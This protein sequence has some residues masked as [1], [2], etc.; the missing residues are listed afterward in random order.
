MSTTQWSWRSRHIVAQAL[1]PSRSRGS[2]PSMAAA[3]RFT[4]TISPPSSTPTIPSPTASR[5]LRCR[6]ES[7]CSSL[8][9]SSTLRSRS[10]RV[11]WLSELSTSCRTAV[12][13]SVTPAI[14]QSCHDSRPVLDDDREG[15]DH[16]EVGEHRRDGPRRVPLD[17]A[18]LQR[19]SGR[20][21]RAEPEEQRGGHVAHSH[22]GPVVLEPTRGE[23]GVAVVGRR[24]GRERQRHQ[25]QVEAWTAR[26]TDQEQDGE[27]GQEHVGD[28]V[29]LV[30]DRVPGARV[31][32]PRPRRARAAASRAAARCPA[33]ARRAPAASE[34]RAPT[35][36]PGRSPA[37][38]PSGRCPAG[39]A[40]RPPTSAGA[41]R[42]RR[43]R[44]TRSC[45]RPPTCPSSRRTVPRNGVAAPVVT[46]TV[47]RQQ[48]RARYD[49]SMLTTS[50]TK[51]GSADVGPSTIAAAQ[52]TIRT[53]LTVPARTIRRCSC[54]RVSVSLTTSRARVPARPGPGSR[55]GAAGRSWV[56][57]GSGGQTGAASPLDHPNTR[58][59]PGRKPQMGQRSR[60]SPRAVRT[61]GAPSPGARSARGRDRP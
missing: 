13:A 51:S 36:P 21:E 5:M 20:A 40:S 24:P 52:S 37:P 35:C 47:C 50:A 25:G 48:T 19:R 32:A 60:I 17:G 41:A 6:S 34:R 46:R 4:K 10:S 28:R 59:L 7:S 53:V 44:R 3:T 38:P 23:Q 31:R 54:G 29:D 56:G 49:A 39:R 26:R 57:P 2:Q 11:V 22:E 14:A 8:V 27:R 42:S 61:A 12:Q 1:R 16:H 58:A 55:G 30:D 45:R 9:R 15:S 18:L 33:R 43:R